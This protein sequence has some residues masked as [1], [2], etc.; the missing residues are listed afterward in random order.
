M[1][2]IQANKYR[3]HLCG[4][5]RSGDIDKDVVLSGWVDTVRDMGGVIFVDIRDRTGITQAVFDPQ[6]SSE[7]IHESAK[8]LR[9]EWVVS[10]KG[11]VCKRPEDRANA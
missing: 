4:E 6:R 10:I 9:P 7:N 2:S 5:L 1:S 11:K 3:T 8:A